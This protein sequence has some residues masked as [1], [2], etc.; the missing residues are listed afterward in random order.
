MCTINEINKG[1]YAIRLVNYML[2]LSIILSI[3]SIFIVYFQY[4]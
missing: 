2:H 1:D 3:F 4:I